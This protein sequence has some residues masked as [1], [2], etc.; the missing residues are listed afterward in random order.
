[1]A[2]KSNRI[3]E[4]HF[5]DNAL[6]PELFGE[7]NKNLRHI[8]SFL[9]VSLESMGN[10]LTIEGAHAE[11]TTAHQAID[12]LWDRLQ[13]GEPIE[14]SDVDAALRIATSRADKQSKELAMESFTHPSKNVKTNR[15]S[16]AP[17]ST[18][19]SNYMKAIDEND[20]V[21]GIGPAGTGKTYLAVA[22]AVE[23]L[24]GGTVNKLIFSRPAVE[25]GE[26]LGFLP[27]DMQE[28]IDPYL[29]PIYDALSDM[30]PTD[31]MVKLMAEGKIEIA[32]LAFMRGRTLANCFVVLDEAQNTTSMQMKM[33]LT[34]LGEDSRMIINGDITQTDLPRGQISGLAEAVELL[35][36]EKGIKICEFSSEDV[37]RHPLVATI[38]KAYEKKAKEVRE[39]NGNGNGHGK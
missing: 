5:D 7:Q 30:I 10:V 25:A 3:L 8:E 29:R 14:T 6:L 33:L 31:H 12:A 21:F 17:R 11:V 27:G 37:V 35:K 20:L 24:L 19:Q 34:R 32:P 36:E 1:M 26:N 13:N 4:L 23:K 18:A 15:K 28:K 39:G 9:G 16:I 2:K 22:K 38:I